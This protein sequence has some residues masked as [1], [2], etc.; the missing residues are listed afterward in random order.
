M[1][2]KA[3]VSSSYRLPYYLMNLFIRYQYDFT[4][5]WILSYICVCVLYIVWYVVKVDWHLSNVLQY[6]WYYVTLLRLHV[7]VGAWVQY[8]S[9]PCCC[10]FIQPL[11]LNKSRPSPLHHTQKSC[12]MQLKYCIS[13]KLLNKCLNLPSQNWQVCFVI[14]GI[15]EGLVI[16]RFM[17]TTWGPGG[18]HVGPGDFAISQCIHKSSVATRTQWWRY[19]RP[20]KK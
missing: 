5:V 15:F 10:W 18:P 4:N 16:A 7:N 1:I 14:S 20:H 17:G 2:Y 8:T 3:L 19:K 11:K 12:I 6:I 13:V 9:Y